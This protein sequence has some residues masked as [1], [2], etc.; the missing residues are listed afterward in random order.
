[1]IMTTVVAVALGFAPV[2]DNAPPQVV[3]GD[4]TNIVGSYSQRV[5]KNGVTHL[6]GFNRLNGSPYDLTVSSDGKVE[7]SVG[8]SYVTFTVS[9]AS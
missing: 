3:S 4:Y 6:S 1:M 2:K 8:E 9:E 7:G 5:D